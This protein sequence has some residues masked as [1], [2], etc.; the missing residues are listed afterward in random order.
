MN[1]G[2]KTGNVGV[3]AR[4]YFA[5]A[6]ASQRIS[7]L[8]SDRV[9]RE[10]RDALF[11]GKLQAGDYL[12]TESDLIRHF[13]VSRAPMRDALKSLSALGIIEIRVGGN[14]GIYIAHGDAVKFAEAL[15]IQHKLLGISCSEMFDLQIAVEEMA[16]ELAIRNAADEELASLAGIIRESEAYTTDAPAFETKNAE[17]H[18]AIA[19]ASGN[20]AIISQMRVY[21]EML[22]RYFLPAAQV[23]NQASK[24]D[25]ALEALNSNKHLMQFLIKRDLDGA[26]GQNRRYWNRL[27]ELFR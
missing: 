2:A 26:H 19:R 20:R 5:G 11:S 24:A 7:R 23:T 1:V 6:D 27:R 10:I 25:L 8:S 3:Y 21:I 9:V 13:S 18:V 15:S 22:F 4:E 17:F 16:I 12:G 14:G